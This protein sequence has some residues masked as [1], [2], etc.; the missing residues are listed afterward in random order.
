MADDGWGRAAKTTFQTPSRH[1]SNRIERG[2][3]GLVDRSVDL[4]TLQSSAAARGARPPTPGGPI[5]EC[6]GGACG[7][8]HHHPGQRKERT[9]A[10]L[11]MGATPLDGPGRRRSSRLLLLAC[12]PLV[13]SAPC[14]FLP[15][16]PPCRS[17]GSDSDGSEWAVQSWPKGSPPLAS[18]A[19][20]IRWLGKREGEGPSLTHTNC[21]RF[22][23]A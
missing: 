11:W 21:S 16:R 7:L 17:L 1:R 6:R 18:S 23:F 9:L 19:T 8:S 2:W 5:F 20:A 13:P 10:F 3:G 15:S 4:E 14:P 12:P 22:H